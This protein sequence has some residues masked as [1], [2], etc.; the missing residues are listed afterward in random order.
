MSY[1][2]RKLRYG[3]HDGEAGAHYIA[4]LEL[5]KRKGGTPI[6]F[7]LYR[8]VIQ[9]NYPAEHRTEMIRLKADTAE[10]AIKRF[11]LSEGEGT[12]KE[13]PGHSSVL[14]EK[15]TLWLDLVATGGGYERFGYENING[16]VHPGIWVKVGTPAPW[17]KR[18]K[19]K[20]LQFGNM[21]HILLAR[22]SLLRGLVSEESMLA[23]SASS[24]NL[25]DEEREGIYAPEF[26]RR[27]NGAYS[28]V[29]KMLESIRAEIEL[30]EAS[31]KATRAEMRYRVRQMFPKPG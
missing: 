29:T 11:W 5:A 16:N 18:R 3:A 9:F 27:I 23:I 30:A 15:T 2:V 14:W 20:P 17:S 12:G 1:F 22:Q 26:G 6:E 21:G 13:F 31:I 25:F 4:L 28:R 7:V 24:S 19:K 10:E 8:R